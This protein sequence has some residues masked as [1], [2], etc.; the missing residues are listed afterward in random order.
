MKPV[1]TFDI[2]CVN[3]SR[4]MIAIKIFDSNTK[5]YRDTYMIDY[6]NFMDIK[7]AG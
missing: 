2:Q 1:K 7:K 4:I 6:Q 3:C 5:I